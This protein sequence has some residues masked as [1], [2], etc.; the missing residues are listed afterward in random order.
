[1]DSE[2]DNTDPRWSYRRK[3]AVVLDL[4]T[5]RETLAGLAHDYDL[6]VETLLAWRD[7]VVRAERLGQHPK[8]S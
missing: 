5:G 4:L 6:Q 1:M 7:Q 8:A 2:A 3:R